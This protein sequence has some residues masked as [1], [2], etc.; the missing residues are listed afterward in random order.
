MHKEKTS[1]VL[2][3]KAKTPQ[4]SFYTMTHNMT[5]LKEHSKIPFEGHILLAIQK[6][7]IM[8]V[9]L[10]MSLGP[11]CGQAQASCAMEFEGSDEGGFD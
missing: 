9:Y 8:Q 3:L 6:T 10:M 5:P 4:Y 11:T 1:Y 7:N 2:S